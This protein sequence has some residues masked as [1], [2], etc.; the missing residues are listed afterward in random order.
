VL[1]DERDLWLDR[2]TAVR[3]FGPHAVRRVPT[4]PINW[5]CSFGR[6]DLF[7]S[8]QRSSLA[9]SPDG[10]QRCVLAL[11][12]LA[13]MGRADAYFRIG[14]R[15]T[16]AGDSGSLRRLTDFGSRGEDIQLVR[17]LQ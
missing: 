6:L 16:V 3:M 15:S 11:G 10:G 2:E 17:R 13:Y 7:V 12:Y 8:P 14:R 5:W 1:A 9:P 4:T